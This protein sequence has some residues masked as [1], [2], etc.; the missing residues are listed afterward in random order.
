MC[1][2]LL[3][4][5]F[6]VLAASLVCDILQATNRLLSKCSEF[7][8]YTGMVVCIILQATSHSLLRVADE[9]YHVCRVQC[10]HLDGLTVAMTV[11]RAPGAVKLGFS[12]VV[13]LLRLNGMNTSLLLGVLPA[14]VSL[15]LVAIAAAASALTQSFSAIK[16]VLICAPSLRLAAAAV[17][18][19]AC[20]ISSVSVTHTEDIVADNCTA[21]MLSLHSGT[22]ST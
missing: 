12:S 22:A 18:A 3:Q 2:C 19:V 21:D 15:V 4:R 7:T 20:A 17:V 8:A 13:K 9:F 11:V 5:D 6:T 10:T 14:V 1:H 16:P